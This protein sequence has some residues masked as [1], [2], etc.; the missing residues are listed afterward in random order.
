MCGRL[1]M[2]WLER[3]MYT[4]EVI[5]DCIEYQQSGREVDKSLVFRENMH[6][7]PQTRYTY[8]FGV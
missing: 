6:P 5:T 1:A 4:N 3:L 8:Y 7:R 2:L